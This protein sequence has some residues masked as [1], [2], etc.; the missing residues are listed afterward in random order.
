MICAA[1]LAFLSGCAAFR[2]K[3]SD[4]DVEKDKHLQS[5]Y[6]YTD[7][8]KVTQSVVDE[9]VASPFLS[10]HEKPPI[11]VIVGV[12]NRTKRYVDTKSLT[13]RMRTLLFKSGKAQFV[14]A[15]RRE[16][17]MKE[18]KHQAAHATAETRVAIGRQI[19][20]RYMV[21]GSLVE[22]ESESP[23]QVRVSKKKV[24]Y[25]Q[26]TIEVTDLETGLMT[27]TTEKEFAREAR[28]PLIGW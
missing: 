10:K 23:R 9:I 6:D 16:Q 15:T 12:Q 17:L 13:D 21:S 20:A 27:W 25:Y 28:L 26:L 18:Q 3:M 4:V 8:R 7:M 5:T 24:N 2:A 22:M 14:N 19:G 1:A 11:M